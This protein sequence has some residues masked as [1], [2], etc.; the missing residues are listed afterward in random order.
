MATQPRIVRTTG[1]PFLPRLSR[2]W[3][4]RENRY[5][6]RMLLALTAAL[7]LMVGLARLPW[8]PLADQTGWRQTGRS[9]Q[10]HFDLVPEPDRDP[11]PPEDPR[12]G[13]R[14]PAT[15]FPVE[16]RTSEPAAPNVGDAGPETTSDQAAERRP[17]SRSDMARMP[18]L[19]FAEEQPDIVGGL[20]SLYL[21]IRYPLAAQQAG[22]QGL[23]V[24]RF[25]VEI[26]G[27]AS[28]I[29][30]A[31]SLHPLCDAA[32]VEAV[33]QTTFRPARQNGQPVRVRMSLPIRFL[34]V[35]EQTGEPIVPDTSRAPIDPDASA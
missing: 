28:D 4:D 9:S 6:V 13:G 12:T 11:T 29:E 3:P 19:S 10:V 32:A 1:G 14:V 18:V 25:I 20:S 33:R 30:V 22:V 7:L 5:R 31:R 2:P 15:V 16:P 24:L 27:R 26:D 8:A 35:N 17:P 21:R 23:V 34:L